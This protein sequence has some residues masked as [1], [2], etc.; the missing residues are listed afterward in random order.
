MSAI[1][2]SFLYAETADTPMHVAALQIYDAGTARNGVDM[3]TIVAQIGRRAH[4]IDCFHDKLV[5]APW[6][7]DH[8]SWANDPDFDPRK[9]VAELTLPAPGDWGTLQRTGGLSDSPFRCAT[10]AAATETRSVDA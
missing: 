6:H 4:L 2:A 5:T 7:L 3:E 9:H 8:P 1:D 10:P